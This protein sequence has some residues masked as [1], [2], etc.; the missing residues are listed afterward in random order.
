[1]NTLTEESFASMRAQILLMVPLQ[2]INKVF[3][4]FYKRNNREKFIL[5]PLLIHKLSLLR[6][7]TLSLSNQSFSKKEKPVCKY[8]EITGYIIY[9]CY[10]LQSFLPGYKPK[11]RSQSMANQVVQTEHFLSCFSF[12]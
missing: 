12:F 4:L 2:S 9:K 7:V 6:M 1:M 8:C 3:L 11:P 5:L 10:K